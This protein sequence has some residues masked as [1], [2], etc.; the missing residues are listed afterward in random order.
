L[1]TYAF[2]RI[3]D[4]T[5]DAVTTA[6]VMAVLSPIWS[7]KPV[8]AKRMR[9]RIGAVMKW[10]R[11]GPAHGQPRRRGDLRRAAEE[12]GRPE[13]PARCRTPRSAPREVCE[14]ALAH[15]NTDRV[16]AAYRRT[17]LFD[18]RPR[19]MVDWAAYVA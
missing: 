19:L 16:E 10:A 4:K 18:R 6:D 2:P 9:Q 12:H 11:A 15:V 14:L 13:A 1:G 17:D 5:V 7:A 8:T 3:G